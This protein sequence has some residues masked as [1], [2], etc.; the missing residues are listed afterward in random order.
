MKLQ[1]KLGLLFVTAT[2]LLVGAF[3]YKVQQQKNYSDT[4]LVYKS[5]NKVNPFELY[6]HNGQLVNNKSIKGKWNLV[7]LGYLSCPD[8]CPMTM[9]KLSRV[10]PELNKVSDIPVQVLFV[11]VDPQRDSAEKRKQYVEYFDSNILGVSAEQ[12]ALFPFVRN[13]GLMYSIPDN[14]AEDYFVDHSA[15]VVLIGP[16]GNAVAKFKPQINDNQVPTI[17][18]KAMIADFTTLI[19]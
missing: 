16:N 14:G 3:Y 2:V 5:P 15:S 11:S 12:E 6:D 4:T 8:I 10:L 7:F 17:N 13:L 18:P 9:A 1:Q 19:E